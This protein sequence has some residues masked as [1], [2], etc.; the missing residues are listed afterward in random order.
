MLSPAQQGGKGSRNQNAEC[1]SAWQKQGR[2]HTSSRTRARP[3][4]TRLQKHT[5]A[6]PA[7]LTPLSRAPDA[8][9]AQVDQVEH[10]A[11]TLITHSSSIQDEHN[12]STPNRT[13]R[14]QQRL[15]TLSS[16][17]TR[18]AR[19]FTPAS[20]SSCRKHRSAHGNG[21]GLALPVMFHHELGM[22]EMQV[23]APSLLMFWYPVLPC[24]LVSRYPAPPSLYPTPCILF[25][26]PCILQPTPY[27][28]TLY[29]LPTPYLPLDPTPCAVNHT[30]YTLLHPRL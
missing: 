18:R 28:C 21:G 1:M 25:T 6:T 5:Q 19:S 24:L 30:L 26:T 4:V 12:T 7:S 17:L 8:P 29:P 9:P 23:D 20:R 27:T 14:A 2:R 10:L 15:D 13:A 11:R 22:T 16:V 3:R